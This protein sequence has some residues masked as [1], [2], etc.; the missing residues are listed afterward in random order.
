M[1]GIF[2][3]ISYESVCK[4]WWKCTNHPRSLIPFVT[5]EILLQSTQSA[6]SVAWD[7]KFHS[8]IE[9][10]VQE[11]ICDAFPPNVQIRVQSKSSYKLITV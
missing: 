10:E 1:N 9:Q 2:Q 5:G 7:K 8:Q 6:T 4:S 3:R 11:K